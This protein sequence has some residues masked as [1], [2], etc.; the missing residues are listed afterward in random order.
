MSDNLLTVKEAASL[1]KVHWQTIRNYIKEGKIK[2]HKV[3]RNIRIRESEL[4]KLIGQNDNSP[5][6]EVEIRFATKN[7]KKI[8]EKLLNMNAKIIYHGHI[9]DHWYAPTNIKNM[10]QKNTFY[11]NDKGYGIRIREQDNGYTGKIATSLEVKKLAYPPDHSICLE[12]EI[13][14][15]DYETTHNFLKLI[16]QKEF[17]TLDKDRLIYKYKNFK[18]VIDDIKNFLT[19]VEIEVMTNNSTN[20]LIGEMKKLAEK[21]GLDTDK[22]ITDKSVTFLYMQRFANF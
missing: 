6:Q 21:I 12:E 1:L 15:P 22:E 3:G 9:I 5:L 8:E 17:T 19:G 18:I 4:N 20:K 16:N 14:V 11:E 10:S 7:R 2:A 13:D